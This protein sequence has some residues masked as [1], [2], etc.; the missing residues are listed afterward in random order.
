MF[1]TPRYTPTLLW[2]EYYLIL[3]KIALAMHWHGGWV[4]LFTP[5][6][7][8]DGLHPSYVLTRHTVI[9]DREFC[10]RLCYTVYSSAQ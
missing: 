4:K 9:Y 5:L 2:G 3:L 1:L 6:F 7:K 10:A 8:N